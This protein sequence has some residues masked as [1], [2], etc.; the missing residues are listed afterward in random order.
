MSS[1]LWNGAAT[2][3][4]AATWCDGSTAGTRCVGAVSTSNSLVGTTASDQVGNSGVIDL[5]NGNYVVRSPLWNNGATADVGAVTWCNGTA[6]CTGAV[7]NANSLH[8]STL[9]DSL[10]ASSAT[11]ITSGSQEDNLAIPTPL[12]NNPSPTLTDVGAITLFNTSTAGPRTT[13]P[14]N[15]NNSVL[16]TV[17]SQRLGDSQIPLFDPVN[18]R[19]YVYNRNDSDTVTVISFVRAASATSSSGGVSAI[20]ATTTTAPPTAVTNI[21]PRPL[22]SSVTVAEF[23]DRSARLTTDLRRQA[24]RALAR[25]PEAKTVVCR[26]F[27]KTEQLNN[28]RL[29]TLAQ[30]RANRV[31]AYL[32]ALKPSLQTTVVRGAATDGRRR[33]VLT[34]RN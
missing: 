19:I 21:P 2:D 12:W 13:G 18:E 25:H 33:V 26:G 10:G 16:G 17:A 23:A 11:R 29:V 7:S 31:C 3:V 5:D 15:S 22:R 24:R 32:R 9:T 14:I 4:G 34:F 8:G 20:T 30:D 1:Q 6:G 28:E 27:V